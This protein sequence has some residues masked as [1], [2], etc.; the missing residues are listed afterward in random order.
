ME[1]ITLAAPVPAAV[2]FGLSCKAL[3]VPA[4]LVVAIPVLLLL[5]EALRGWRSSNARLL[6]VVERHREVGR[7]AA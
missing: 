7:H 6:R 4:L 2:E 3:F 5:R 1:W